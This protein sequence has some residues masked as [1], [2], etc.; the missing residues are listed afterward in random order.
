MLLTSRARHQLASL[1][2]RQLLRRRD[3]IKHTGALDFCS[4]DYLRLSRHPLVLAAYHEGIERYGL[5]SGASPHVSGY[6]DAHA[7]LENEFARYLKRDAA[8][9][10]NSGYHANL[11]M[12]T[13]FADHDTVVIADKLSHASL[14]DGVT[15][16]QATLKRYPHHGSEHAEHLL[17]TYANQDRLLITESVFSIRGDIAPVKTLASLAK[18]HQAMLIVDDAHGFGVLG[19]AGGGICDELSLSQTDVPCLVIPLGKAIGSAGAIVAGSTETIE[20]INQCARAYRYS[21]ALPPA[22]CH[23]T[24]IALRVLMTEPWHREQL[25]QRIHFFNHTARDRNIPLMSYDHSAIKS[26]IIGDNQSALNKQEDLLREGFHTAC[27]RPPTVPP[28][29]ACIRISLHC[30]HQESDILRLLDRV[31]AP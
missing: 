23:A 17:K 24:I 12:I 27:M 31:T 11:G 19:H 26:I 4:N 18:Q 30:D 7:E 13:T 1:A 29:Q 6:T 15:L 25:Q 8:I 14:I 10:F 28:N 3:A 16:A 5:G 2:S 9:L 20:A 22:V 21:T